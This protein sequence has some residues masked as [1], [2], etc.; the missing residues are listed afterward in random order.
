M[1]DVPSI[2]KMFTIA[3]DLAPE[4]TDAVRHEFHNLYSVLDK[5]PKD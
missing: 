4:D 2:E 3:D 5:L 1:I